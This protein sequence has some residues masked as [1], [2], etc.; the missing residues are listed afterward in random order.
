M[1]HNS[2][3]KTI[4]REEFHLWKFLQS[5]W[6]KILIILVCAFFYAFGSINFLVKSASIPS[7]LSAISITLSYIFIDLKKYLTLIYL[8]LNIPLIVFF[9]FKIKRK[10]MV[11]TIIFL[12]SNALFGFIFGLGPIS[13]FFSN[14][15]F[16]FIEN[17]NQIQDGSTQIVKQGWPIFV[18]VVLT[19]AFCAP[20]GALVW[21]QGASTGG[22]DIVAHFF[23]TKKKKDV[24]LFLVII[25][26]IMATISLII[27]VVIK[28]YGP[29][30]M[31]QNIN[32][33]K[34]LIGI[35]TVSSF[36]YIYA[37]GKLLNML[38][39]KYKKVKLKIDSKQHEVIIKWLEESEYWHPYK[40]TE[41]ISGYTK[42][43]NYTIESVVLLLES[44]DIIA[45]IKK[46]EPNSWIAII[47]V[48]KIYGRFNYGSVE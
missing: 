28:S 1:Q 31:S 46:I 43:K 30:Y 38:Y 48:T 17:A 22:T 18:Y 25:G 14:K 7:G 40:V 10:F 39:P 8:A 29:S 3:K 26:Y 42:Q 34:H 47:P 19:L 11:L 2:I 27:I 5:N 33:F 4:D 37:N 13:D 15:V 23:S 45:K 6:K 9:W 41:S 32:G 12:L 20:T 24:G 16:V 21:K 35:Q 44:E 36:V